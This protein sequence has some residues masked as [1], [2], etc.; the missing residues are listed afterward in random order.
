MANNRKSTILPILSELELWSSGLY[1]VF[2]VKRPSISPDLVFTI[3]SNIFACMRF[4]SLVLHAITSENILST[5]TL[6]TGV[7]KQVSV[8]V[9]RSLISECYIT[10]NQNFSVSSAG[11]SYVLKE[12]FSLRPTSRTFLYCSSI[13]L[14]LMLPNRSSAKDALEFWLST[15]FGLSYDKFLTASLAYGILVSI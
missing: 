15:N 7:I 4:S 9:A 1:T 5:M 13:L 6:L 10:P 11:R 3:E 14:F 12:G 2:D 8:N